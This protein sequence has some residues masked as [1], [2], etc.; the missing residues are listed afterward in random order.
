V[1]DP[2]PFGSG[3]GTFPHGDLRERIFG[4]QDWHFVLR[5]TPEEIQRMFQRE[6]TVLVI[7]WLRRERSRV[8]QVMR[9]HVGVA[10]QSE[11][12]QLATETRL[13]LSYFLFLVLCNSLI[14]WV[15]FYGPVRTR[16][17]VGQT[18]KWAAQVR[19]A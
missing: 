2:R 12:L 16:K 17:L 8:S 7:S 6:R 11:N 3:I 9:A 10:R 18:L 1:S 13:A 19:G 14:G 4:L 5:E 15:W